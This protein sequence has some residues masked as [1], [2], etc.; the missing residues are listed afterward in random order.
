[1]YEILKMKFHQGGIELAQRLVD[2]PDS[3]EIIERTTWNGT[4][5]GV[6]SQG[7]GENVLGKLLM[8]LRNELRKEIQGNIFKNEY[9]SEKLYNYTNPIDNFQFS[10]F[11]IMEKGPN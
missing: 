10:L 4:Y 1:M 3:I 5:W 2:I 6:D 8:R 11:D 9:E 7:N